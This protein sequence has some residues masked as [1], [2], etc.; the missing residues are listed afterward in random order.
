MKFVKAEDLRI[1]MRLA[2][3]IYNNKGVL[4]YDRN[5]KL[6][7]Q[8]IESVRNFKLIGL[9]VLEPAEPLPPMSMEDMDFEKF[10]MVSVFAVKDELTSIIQSGRS[11]KIRNLA[12]N[13]VSKYGRLDHK[14]NFIQNLR[15]SSD[16]VYKHSLNVAIL[17]AMIL[18]K[19]GAR[20]EEKVEGVIA[21]LV[22]DIGKLKLDSELLVSEELDDVQKAQI[23]TAQYGGLPLIEDSFLAS[24]NIKRSVMQAFKKID[25]YDN[26]SGPDSAKMVMAA[27][28]LV[29][30]EMYDLMTAMNA[31][32]EPQSEVAVLRIL[33]NNQDYFDKAAV[34]AL[35]KSVNFLAEGCCVELSNG[36]KAL[37]ISS[38]PDDILR[39][40]VLCFST[41]TI[42][43][44]TQTMLYS[45]LEIVDIMKTLDNRHVMGDEARAMFGSEN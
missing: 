22:H 5:S 28:A 6:T 4:L 40:S 8:G 36:E 30:A 17:V 24:P 31:E 35:V 19:M 38:N 21:A 15:S 44:L 25:A 39:P 14:I 18:N 33:S 11:A 2:K 43:D 7:S 13:I 23:R 3:P 10:Q 9:F 12:E 42:V 34:D 41:N 29:V 20:A 32:G 26:Q 37:V 16:F 27:K 1:G 45:D